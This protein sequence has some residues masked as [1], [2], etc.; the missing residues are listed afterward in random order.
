MK[1]PNE[2]EN[3]VV[4]RDQDLAP[5]LRWNGPYDLEILYPIYVQVGRID[6]MPNDVSVVYTPSCRVNYN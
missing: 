6:E 4:I 3:V 1:L 2:P 5:K